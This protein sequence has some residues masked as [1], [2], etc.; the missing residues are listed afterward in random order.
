MQDRPTYQELLDAV[1]SFLELDV[2]PA[3]EGAKKFHARVAANV[4][5]IVGRELEL[6]REHL[7]E[8]WLRLDRL[9]G[10][11]PKPADTPA[12]KT[13][14][15]QRTEALCERIRSG[16]A[17]GGPFRTAVLDHVRQTVR[18]KLAIDNPKLLPGSTGTNPQ[19]SSGTSNP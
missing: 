19:R 13:A 5:A 12:L 3:L 8:E 14:L 11:V 18:E 7:D 16:E 1:R 4:V 2:V 10:P 17:D 15:R 9:L 6:E